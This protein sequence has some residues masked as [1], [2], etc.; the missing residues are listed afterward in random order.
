MQVITE[1]PMKSM[2]RRVPAVFAWLRLLR[3]TR[4]V[5]RLTGEALRCHALSSAQ[6]AVLA[7]VGGAEGVAQARLAE[8]LAVTE[9]NVCQLLDRMQAAGL[10]ERRQEGRAKRVYLGDRGR[11]LVRDVLPEHEALVADHM[12]ALDLD[13]QRELLRLLRKLDHSLNHQ[14]VSR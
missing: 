10:I 9:G 5:E 4:R 3:V 12:A 14:G 2:A 8:T 13:E 1:M 7:R 6:L 11:D